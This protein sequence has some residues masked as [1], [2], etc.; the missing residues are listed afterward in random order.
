MASSVVDV[1]RVLHLRSSPFLGSPEKLLLSQLRHLDRTRCDYVV[2]IFDEQ[3]PASN[4][5][6]ER[7]RRLCPT[8]LLP[9]HVLQLPGAL[10]A[11]R[12]IARRHSVRCICTHD[13]KSTFVGALAARASGIPHLAVFH[14]RTGCS[15]R[16]RMYEKLDTLFL[17]KSDAVVAVS[18]AVCSSLADLGISRERIHHIPNAV[19][20]QENAEGEHGSIRREFGIALSTPMIVY[21]GRLSPEK[22]LTVL[23][24]AAKVVHAVF[25]DAVFFL[26]GDGPERDAL[27]HQIRAKNLEAHCFLPGFR[28]DI[29]AFY[30]DMNVFVLPSLTEGMP[31]AVLEA[32]A[33][34]K[35][36]V[37]TRV[38]GIPEVL[39][40]GVTG[41][42]VPPQ[43]AARLAQALVV[44][45]SDTERAT[46][47]GARGLARVRTEFSARKHVDRYMAMFEAVATRAASV[48]KS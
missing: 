35:P 19:E 27:V 23:V 37:A 8:Y 12:R 5:F 34:A 42:L 20:C 6:A 13:Y 32:L 47:I 39:D 46:Q 7:C 16:V 29:G 33:Y 2:G 3:R 48:G 22:G 40:D 10:F 15:R 28:R 43:D 44:L 11:V 24:E 38:G 4:E 41:L 18:K 17:K 1:I 9:Q 31:L 21:A 25:P 14:G 30:R 26:A 45:L 36:V